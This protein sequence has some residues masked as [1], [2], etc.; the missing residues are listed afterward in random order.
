MS[1][2]VPSQTWIPAID[3]E[4]QAGTDVFDNLETPG[5]VTIV[6]QSR[7]RPDGTA[8]WDVSVSD[9]SSAEEYSLVQDAPHSSH[10]SRWG[11]DP[12]SVLVDQSA[13]W[14]SELVKNYITRPSTV[15]KV[16]WPDGPNSA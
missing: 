12:T 9:S 8:L 2:K 11:D 6:I 10:L 4:P 7:K 15:A 5:G 1:D 14:I 13:T 3:G 16:L